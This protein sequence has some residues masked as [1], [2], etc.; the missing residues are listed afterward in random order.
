MVSFGHVTKVCRLI[1]LDASDLRHII[2][3]YTL[4]R[5]GITYM[6][7]NILLFL[8]SPGKS[9]VAYVFHSLTILSDS[10]PNPPNKIKFLN[11][12]L[13]SQK[14]YQHLLSMA[15]QGENCLLPNILLTKQVQPSGRRRLLQYKRIYFPDNCL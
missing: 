3:F 13:P 9:L 1:M 7:K 15:M 8:C 5:L 11:Q 2:F 10:Q 4:I 12:K 14:P 6:S